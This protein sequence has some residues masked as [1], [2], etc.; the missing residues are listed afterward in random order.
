MPLQVEAHILHTYANDFYGKELRVV[1]LGFIRP[2]MKMTSL[3]MLITRIKVDIALASE[4]L[5][6][7]AALA[8]KSDDFFTDLDKKA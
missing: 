2:E 4:V 7:D 5:K 3:D 8:Y 1:V 6:G